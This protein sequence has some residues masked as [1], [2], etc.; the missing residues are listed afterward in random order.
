MERAAPTDHRRRRELLVTLLAVLSGATD[1]VGFLALGGAFTSVMTGNMVLLGLSAGT[2]DADLAWHA[3]AA[4][5]SFAAGVALG[6][7]LAGAPRPDDGLWPRAVTRALTVELALFTVFAVAW[8]IAGGK[9][10]A[11]LT[12]VLLLALTAVALGLQ[13]GAILRFGVPGLSTTYL[14]GTLTTAVTALVRGRPLGHVAQQ[15][16]LLAGVIAGAA[17][18]G[19]LVTEAPRLAPLLQ[20]ALLA[21]VL[22]GAR[23]VVRAG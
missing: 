18:G 20:L 10:S 12:Q 3:G 14:T 15:G 5:V 9:P 11:E 1:A 2:R 23:G 8:Q 13:S 21:A 22:A 16:R 17:A 6:A 7:R 4:I 19:V